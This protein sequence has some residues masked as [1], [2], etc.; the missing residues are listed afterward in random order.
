MAKKRRGWIIPNDWDGVSQSLLIACIP[1]S[2][3]WKSVVKGAIYLL[4]R[5]YEWDE[6]TGTVTVA[7]AI[8]KDIYD[9]MGLCEELLAAVVDI[10][11]T[12]KANS[13]GC[14]I[15][16]AEDTTEGE[17]GG[18]VPP[19][20]GDIVFTEPSVTPDRDCKAAN[21]VHRFLR[22]LIAE[23]DSY[24]V[25][26]MGTLG[27]ALV[28][29]IITGVLGSAVASPL[30]GVVLAVAG[31]LSVFAARL[32][33]VTL[34][35]ANMLSVMTTNGQDLVCALY[36]A[37][38]AAGARTD[39]LAICTSNGMSSVEAA[40]LELLMTNGLMNILWFDTAETTAYWPTYTPEFDCTSCVEPEGCP[41]V[42]KDNQG[43]TGTGDLTKNG[44]LRT[45]TATQ[46]SGGLYRVHV[47]LDTVSGS[48]GEDCDG[49]T[50]VNARYTIMSYN[51][52]SPTFTTHHPWK[53]V[54]GVRTNPG[55]WPNPPD[56]VEREASELV[57]TDQDPFTIDIILSPG[58][59]P[60]PP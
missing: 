8:G 41:W 22:E 48:P 54:N 53:W 37:T 42:F 38:T 52:A 7:Q 9:S 27:L 3:Q 57:W 47:D 43:P 33:G 39:Y 36:N 50:Y 14:N 46:G 17:S 21:E 29:S 10:G 12:L 60:S 13:C 26:D 6:T 28:V 23:L 25:D 45:L 19:P 11:N 20:I 1:D 2:P 59:Y 51:P 32:L 31:A 56:Q 30:A 24:N 18:T 5:G 16:Q 44:Q 58:N 55:N 15:G 4:T 49:E 34:D 35:L 40:A